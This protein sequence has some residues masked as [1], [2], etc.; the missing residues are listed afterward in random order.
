MRLWPH[1]RP[2]DSC[3]LSADHWRVIAR[4]AA[5]S[6]LKLQAEYHDMVKQSKPN[7]LTLQEFPPRQEPGSFSVGDV[8]A[9]LEQNK[10]ALAA[11]SK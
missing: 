4:L 8:M 1:R 7:I 11:A 10:Q 6:E 3:L 5:P 9:R 2:H